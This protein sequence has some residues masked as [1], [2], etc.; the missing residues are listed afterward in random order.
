MGGSAGVYGRR[1]SKQNRDELR[2]NCLF[3]STLKIWYEVDGT[4][5][6]AYMHGKGQEERERKE[7]KQ[8]THARQTACTLMAQRMH[9]CAAQ[10]KHIYQSHITTVHQAEHN[11]EEH[12][13]DKRHIM[14]ELGMEIEGEW[15]RLEDIETKQ[16]YEKLD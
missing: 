8:T 12:R 11:D 9:E 3:E 15:K 7:W 14:E 13:R 2:E 6:Y 4:T 10:F 5:N 16:I 1:I